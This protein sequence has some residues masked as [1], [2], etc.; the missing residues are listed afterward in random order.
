MFPALTPATRAIILVNVVVFLVEQVA[1][2][3]M[4]V[5][6]ALWPL[7]TPEGLFRPWQLVTY[8]F[9]HEGILHIFFNMFALYVFG[10]A[11]ESYWGARRFV[12]YYFV[13]VLAAGATQLAVEYLSGVGEPTIGASGGIFGILLAFAMLFPRVRL[14]LYFAIPVPAWLF[15]TGYA[16]LELFF[17]VTGRQASVA[18]FAHLGGMLG[19][20][21]MMLFWRL[22][23]GRGGWRPS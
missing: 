11:L 21:I 1:M 4:E 22:R 20:A 13:C 19:G 8:A 17:G 9:L 6:F 12:G 23:A 16:V 2:L 5:H 3:P 18:H 7:G 15:V 10:P 14:L